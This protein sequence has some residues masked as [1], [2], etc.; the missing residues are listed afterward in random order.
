MTLCDSTPHLSTAA[1]QRGSRLL[2]KAS[3]CLRPCEEYPQVT[4]FAS[5]RS[6]CCSVW[7]T[8]TPT[9]LVGAIF[10]NSCWGNQEGEMLLFFLSP[11]SLC[12]SRDFCSEELIMHAKAGLW[13]SIIWFYLLLPNRNFC[14]DKHLLQESCR[15]I[16]DYHTTQRGKRGKFGS[17]RQN[18]MWGTAES[19]MF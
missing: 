9:L 6:P 18:V 3:I 17:D 15:H 19:R 13:A 2:A 16:E 10:T 8:P 14:I 5:H 4:T 7:S 11:A 12:L 1:L